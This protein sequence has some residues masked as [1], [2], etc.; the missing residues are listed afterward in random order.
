MNRVRH[1]L[2]FTIA[3]VLMGIAAPALA[4]PPPPPGTTL[5]ATVTVELHYDRTYRWTIDKSVAPDTWNLFR[6]DS[7]TSQ[8]TIA[9]TREQTDEAWVDGQVCVTNGGEVATQNLRIVNELRD[10]LP[11]PNDLIATEEVDVS[12]HPVIEPGE[13]WCYP[14]R[15]DIPAANVHPGGTYKVTANVT[16]TNH[17]GHLGEPFGPSPSATGNLPANPTPIGYPTVHVDDTNGG[18]WEFNDSGSVSYS[19]IFSCDGDAGQHSNT[20]TIRETE[21]SDHATVTVNCYALNVTKDAETSYTRTY[22]WTID[23]TADASHLTLSIGQQY[24]VHYEVEVDAS[25]TDSDWA[26]A[27]NIWVYNPAPMA[28]TING[29]ADVVSPDIAAAVSCGVSLPYALG[30]GATLHCTYAAS[31]PDASSR[32]NEATATLQNHDYDSSMNPTPGGTTDFS[33][34]APVAFGDPTSVVDECA[35]VTD[36]YAGSLGTVCYPDVPQIFSYSRWIGPYE[37]CGE[38]TVINTAVFTTTDTGTVG[39][40]SWT[41]VV[42]VPCGGGCTLTP[43]YWK[44]HSA[45]GPAPYDDTW[46]LIG[47]GTPFFLSGQTWYQVLWTPPSGG[48]AYYILAHQYIAARLNILNGAASTPQVDAAIAWA[49]NFFNTYT[50]SSHLSKQLRAQVIA[51]AALLDAYNNGLIGPGHCSE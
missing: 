48:N 18:S 11:P 24:L 20:A 32:T 34:S 35:E 14:Y 29:I 49:T 39:S 17:S 1:L 10:G 42:D 25:Y 6:G 47:E 5:E 45:Y 16:I 12:G 33:G 9:V 28:A 8:Y 7:G 37:S 21:Q 22:S 4:C 46:A 44:T 23:K 50:P 43:G 41:V 27:G 26:V 2:V 13:T 31:L 51:K 36:T 30:S 38:Y 19:K 40:D 3:A 15:I